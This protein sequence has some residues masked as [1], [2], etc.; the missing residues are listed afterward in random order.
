MPVWLLP[1]GAGM[2]CCVLADILGS[3]IPMSRGPSIAAGLPQYLLLGLRDA[4]WETLIS[5]RQ[6]VKSLL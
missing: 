6:L 3:L 1:A 4:V 2:A 5:E